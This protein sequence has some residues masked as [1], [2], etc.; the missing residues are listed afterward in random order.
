MLST[1]LIYIILKFLWRCNW[2]CFCYYWYWYRYRYSYRYRYG[3]R[4]CIVI[5]IVVS[6]HLVYNR[7]HSSLIDTRTILSWGH[8]KMS[9][10]MCSGLNS[11]SHT[12]QQDILKRK[13]KQ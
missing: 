12:V 4:Y 13:V 6:N 9:W 10:R 7:A 3:Y 8:T 11:R 1:R 2:L 5:I